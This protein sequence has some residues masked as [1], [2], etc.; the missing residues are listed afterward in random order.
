MLKKTIFIFLLSATP[1]CTQTISMHDAAESTRNFL[2][3]PGASLI[4][5]AVYIGTATAIT[6]GVFLK[7]HGRVP[8]SD[9]HGCHIEKTL[10]LPPIESACIA[11]LLNQP[12]SLTRAMTIHMGVPLA[13]MIVGWGSNCSKNFTSFWPAFVPPLFG[14]AGLGVKNGIMALVKSK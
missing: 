13:A 3:Q 1:F 14:L 12:M 10:I 6:T 11:F 5:A 2:T 4:D 9:K 8:C 7:W